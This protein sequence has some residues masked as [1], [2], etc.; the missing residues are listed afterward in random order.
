[1]VYKK[2]E[3]FAPKGPPKL[4]ISADEF[5]IKKPESEISYETSEIKIYRENAIRKKLRKFKRVFFIYG[6]I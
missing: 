4:F 5:L 2:S 1:M 3:I 6:G